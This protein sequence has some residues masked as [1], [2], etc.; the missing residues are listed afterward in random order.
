MHL[1]LLQ[2]TIVALA[3]R[4]IESPSLKSNLYASADCRI[5]LY[6]SLHALITSAHH[7]CPPPVQYAATIFNLVQVRDSNAR[8][9]E[10]AASY[11]RT[12]E[13]ILHPQKET[14]YFSAELEEVRDALKNGQ[15]KMIDDNDDDDDEDD[16][17][18]QLNGNDKIH[19]NGNE[20]EIHVNGGDHQT[21]SVE[22]SSP[23]DSTVAIA[24]EPAT[25]AAAAASDYVS[26][27]IVSETENEDENNAS[28]L[29][30]DVVNETIDVDRLRPPHIVSSE[31]S[32]QMESLEVL[33]DSS[34]DDDEL[35]AK[36]AETPPAQ[37]SDEVVDITGDNVDLV[38][39]PKRKSSSK[40]DDVSI[41]ISDDEG[42]GA[43]AAA[44][45]TKDQ[46]EQATEDDI[47]NAFVASF[48]DELNK[49]WS[50]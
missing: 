26:L 3:V 46:V 1:Q 32:D 44:K 36:T 18:I 48:S 33:D 49:N 30:L 15:T 8:V 22:Q 6:G 27:D 7:L 37:A 31:N 17:E 21:N 28:S 39:A 47:V 20:D 5:K 45:R 50:S 25:A 14:L 2:E 4:T 35:T 34:D 41:V 42:S 24:E 16:E 10:A 29:I 13:K 43:A 9:R 40:T 23:V 12:I 11:L 38:R 19:M